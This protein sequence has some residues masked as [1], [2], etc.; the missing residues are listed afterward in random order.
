[1]RPSEGA[2]ASNSEA[3]TGCSAPAANVEGDVTEDLELLVLGPKKGRTA[4]SLK[5]AKIWI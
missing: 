1:V 5:V 4:P 2:G 3:A